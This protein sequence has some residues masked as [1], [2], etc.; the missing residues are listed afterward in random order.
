[1]KTWKCVFVCLLAIS[2]MCS[3]SARLCSKFDGDAEGVVL[4]QQGRVV[5]DAT[6][7]LTSDNTGTSVTTTS[8]SAGTYSIPNLPSA[9]YKIKVDASGSL[10][11]YEPASRCLVLRSQKCR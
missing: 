11:I 3:F 10:P 4:D 7:T 6:I 1:M 2:F 9:S 5:P 8:S